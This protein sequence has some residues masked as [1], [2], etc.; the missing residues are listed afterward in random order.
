MSFMIGVLDL[1]ALDPDDEFEAEE[2]EDFREDIAVLNRFLLAEGYDAFVE[3]G[4][5]PDFRR[6]SSGNH[7]FAALQEIRR[8]YFCVLAG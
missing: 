1:A 5:L 7:S 6:R 4:P 3:P 8:A 2:A